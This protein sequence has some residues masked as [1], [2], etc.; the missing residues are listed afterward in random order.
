MLDTTFI[1]SNDTFD[2]IYFANKYNIS[3][4][5]YWI[6]GTKDRFGR[7]NKDT[8]FKLFITENE[9]VVQHFDDLKYFLKKCKELLFELRENNI[10]MY[11]DI[12]MTI[13]TS[14]YM[15]R[16]FR[17][18]NDILTEITNAGLGIEMSTYIASEE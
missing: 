18:D 2:I 8:G 15:A 7:E 1:A 11:F 13:E 12:G 4:D 16:Y 17:L 9:N 10:N 6:K 3:D 14:K 5:E